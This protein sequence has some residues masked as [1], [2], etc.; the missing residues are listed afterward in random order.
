MEITRPLVIGVTGHRDLVPDEIQGIESIVRALFH[1]LVAR[2]PDRKLQV[3]SPLAEGADRVDIMSLVKQADK[4][5]YWAK[6]AG[7]NQVK[8]YVGTADSSKQS[9]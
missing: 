4:A 3:M 9:S 6:D 1:D 5:M 2:F 7:R 8:I